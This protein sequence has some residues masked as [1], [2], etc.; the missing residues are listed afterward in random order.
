MRIARALAIKT[1]LP[2]GVAGALLSGSAVAVQSA[3]VSVS[4]APAASAG[5]SGAHLAMLYDGSRSKMLY[6]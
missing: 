3:I 1:V 5:A 6:D 2:L 4:S